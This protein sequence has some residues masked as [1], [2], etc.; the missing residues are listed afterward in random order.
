MQTL[1]SEEIKDILPP[2]DF[3]QARQAAA[4]PAPGE[5]L[6]G[7]RTAF[8]I[9]RPDSTSGHIFRIHCGT[10]Q[11]MEVT[12]IASSSIILTVGDARFVIRVTGPPQETGPVL[13]WTLAD[14]TTEKEIQRS[15]N[16]L[17]GLID[18][19]KSLAPLQKSQLF[20]DLTHRAVQQI[21]IRRDEDIEEWANGLADEVA[22]ANE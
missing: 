3:F 8:F 15:L 2:E 1:V 5:K 9:S 10:L 14:E 17:D 11:Q 7:V 22:G 12:E 20:H 4:S 13:T 18:E 6:L 21:A 16:E 19:I